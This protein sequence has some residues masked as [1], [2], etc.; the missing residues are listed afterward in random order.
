MNG[1]ATRTSRSLWC[2]SSRLSSSGASGESSPSSGLAWRLGVLL[3]VEFTLSTEMTLTLTLALAVGLLLGYVFL[4]E[5]RR[6]IVGSLLAVAA[7]YPIAAAISAPFVAYLIGGF[8]SEKFVGSDGGDLLN[9]LVPS[10]L[11]A[12]GG[13]LLSSVSGRFTTNIADRDL[14]IGIPTL[15]AFALYAWRGRR[16][17][18][19]RL[20]VAGFIVA[21]VLALGQTLELAGRKLMRF[22]W[23]FAD[24]LPLLPNANPTRFAG[25]MALTASVAVALWI[26]STSGRWL[27]RPVVLP[28]LA[29]LSIIPASWSAE[30]ARNPKRPEFFSHS[31]YRLCIPKG[32]ALAI[33]P[34]A[35]FGDSMLA[36]VDPDPS[37]PRPHT[38]R[39][40]RGIRPG[41]RCRSRLLVH[42]S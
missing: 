13:S 15:V 30:F 23:H 36:R 26:G 38:R 8:E 27:S 21:W 19:A 41:R 11:T 22:P 29:L 1:A 14:Y 20:L 10:V 35:R 24:S 6:R 34:Y 5:Y 28:V 4:R 18:S 17:G 31:L 39:R 2:P 12:V 3:A 40:A 9:I 25:Y 37:R 16:E 42:G 7:A 32:E 33:F